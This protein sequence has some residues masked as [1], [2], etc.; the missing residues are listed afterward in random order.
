VRADD[1]GPVTIA[2]RDF[3]SGFASVRTTA[4]NGTGLGFTAID[5]YVERAK[6]TKRIVGLVQNDRFR[7]NLAVVHAGATGSDP[8][9]AVT[10]R[11][12]V[13][14]P[15]GAAVGAPLTKSLGPG[16]LHQWTR[17]LADFLGTT[18]EGFSATIERTDGFEPY[19]AYV[20]VIDNASTDPVFVRAE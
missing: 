4:T 16:Q 20:T 8:N 1:Y 5:P 6:G 3:A 17:V 7:T 2:F 19:D 15:S 11:V 14:D 10:L 18:G 9:A 12:T 13:R